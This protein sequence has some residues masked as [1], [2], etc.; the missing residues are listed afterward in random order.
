VIDGKVVSAVRIPRPATSQPGW[1]RS[2]GRPRIPGQ[3]R[4]VAIEGS[5]RLGELRDRTIAPTPLV[6]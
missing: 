6:A 5:V 4:P 2:R 1:A 3:T